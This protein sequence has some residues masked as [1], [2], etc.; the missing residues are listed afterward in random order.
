MAKKK[1]IQLPKGYLSHSQIMMWKSSPERYKKLY[2]DGNQGYALRN[3]SMDFGKKF[4][5]ALEYE[6]ETNDLLTDASILLLPKYDVRDQEIVVEFKTK[7]GWLKLV[8]RP[9]TFNSVSYEFREYKTGITPWTQAKAQKH[10]QMRFYGTIIYLKHKKALPDAYL[11]WIETERL[12]DGT[13]RP[14]G[15]TR[16]FRVEIGL[17][18][19]L[20]TIEET[21][22]V[23][24]EIE[25]AFASHI[26]PPE[27]VF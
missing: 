14:T 20:K 8:G 25:L 19:I 9:D 5:E 11:D 6:K 2:F 18:A 24:L 1:Y 7:H 23:A 15:K 22:K 3:D 21:V 12:P 26:P 27:D 13:I 4:A 17:P 10:H 16:S